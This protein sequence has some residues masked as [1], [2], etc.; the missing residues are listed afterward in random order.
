MLSSSSS[1]T[2]GECLLHTL[3]DVD[4]RLR[5]DGGHGALQGLRGSN[6]ERHA[7]LSSWRR[8]RE[9]SCRSATTRLSRN[10]R[11]PDHDLDAA[12]LAI[13]IVRTSVSP[14]VILAMLERRSRRAGRRRAEHR[15]RVVADD[16]IR[17]LDGAKVAQEC[18]AR[19]R[20]VNAGAARHVARTASAAPAG[21]S[22]DRR[23]LSRASHRPNAMRT[24]ERWND[25]IRIATHR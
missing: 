10:G 3:C 16:A 22:V 5:R 7:A 17:R 4:A 18:R 25:K 21:G 19:R 20:R 1:P 12:L 24:S 9:R 2:V 6:S 14:L 13:R 23:L 15:L 11:V 8:T